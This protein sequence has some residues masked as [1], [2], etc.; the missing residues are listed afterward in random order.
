MGIPDVTDGGALWRAFYPAID[1][2][3]ANGGVLGL[4]EYSTPTM[5]NQFDESSGEGWLTGRYRKVYRHILIPDGRTIPLIITEC[6]IDGGV[7][8]QAGNGWKHYASA[9]E[10]FNQLIWYDGL[11]K[12]D[13]Y[14]L[15]AT[16]FCLEIPDWDSFDIAE[17]MNYLTPY[18]AG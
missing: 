10:Y 8:G 1:A 5:R 3:K 7:I 4:H 12:E 9:Q 2:A 13:S 14:V 6:G 15:G 16:V 11:I 18:V 17:V